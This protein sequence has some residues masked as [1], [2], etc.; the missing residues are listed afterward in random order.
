MMGR[1]RSSGEECATLLALFRLKGSCPAT[2]PREHQP[3][4]P[5]H[6]RFRVMLDKERLGLAQ[7]LLSQ[8]KRAEVPARN[9]W[10]IH[11]EHRAVQKIQKQV[12]N[13]GILRES[14]EW[15][16]VYYNSFTCELQ[17]KIR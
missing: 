15:N 1:A 12:A 3:S 8:A 7:P 16:Y 9:E 5:R 2:L 10:L 14:V 11:I 4:Q 6:S 13:L 17:V